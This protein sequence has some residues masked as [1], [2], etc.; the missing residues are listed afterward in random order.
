M[1]LRM[2]VVDKT[3]F[4]F[5]VAGADRLYADGVRIVGDIF[6]QAQHHSFGQLGPGYPPYFSYRNLYC[7]KHPIKINNN[8]YFKELIILMK[9]VAMREAP[10]TNPP[11]TS[12]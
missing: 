5:Q 10:P 12:G 3:M 4:A 8:I 6:L 2:I 11:S 1:D 9:S 7:F